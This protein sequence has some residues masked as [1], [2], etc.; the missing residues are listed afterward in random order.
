MQN[1]S[2]L[3]S[4]TLT[5]TLVIVEFSPFMKFFEND[6]IGQECVADIHHHI[7]SCHECQIRSFKRLEIPL[8]ISMPVS[9]FSKVYI[10][11]MHMP[12]AHGYKYIVA[13]KD[14]LSGT[15]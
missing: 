7:K 1:R 15:T 14:D 10:D 9:L 8:R 3:F 4:Y 6:F 11:I 2:T 13:A 12:P 5:K